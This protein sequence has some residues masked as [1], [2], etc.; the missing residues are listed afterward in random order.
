MKTKK[1]VKEKKEKRKEKRRTV[2]LKLRISGSAGKRRSTISRMISC[3]NTELTNPV[4][5]SAF[6]EDSK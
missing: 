5:I 6:I 1:K 2:K 3:G 4:D